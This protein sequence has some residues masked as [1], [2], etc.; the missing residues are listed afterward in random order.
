M[1]EIIDLSTSDV[2]CRSSKTTQ[3]FDLSTTEGNLPETFSELLGSVKLN[4][5]INGL[6]L[7]NRTTEP[8]YIKRSGKFVEILQNETAALRHLDALTFLQSAPNLQV[9]LTSSDQSPSS[10]PSEE[11]DE[12]IPLATGHATRFVVAVL[13]ILA[14]LLPAYFFYSSDNNISERAIFPPIDLNLE[15]TDG[16]R[17]TLD[18]DKQIREQLKLDQME[19]VTLNKVAGLPSGAKLNKAPFQLDWTPLEELSP[20]Q[21]TIRIDLAVAVPG[22][23]ITE[24][25]LNLHCEVIETPNPP[26]V[27]EL[28][29]IQLFIADTKTIRLHLLGADPDSPPKPVIFEVDETKLPKGS[30]FNQETST[31]EWL[32]QP[33]QFGT[34]YEIVFKAFKRGV[35]DLSTEAILLID[36]K[37]E[38]KE[39]VS[40]DD[41]VLQAIKLLYMRKT[42]PVGIWIPAATV[43]QLSGDIVL[44]TASTGKV[45]ANS[46]EGGNWQFAV[47]R[48]D[49]SPESYKPLISLLMHEYYLGGEKQRSPLTSMMNLALLKIPSDEISD[50]KQVELITPE[51]I[52]GSLIES[53]ITRVSFDSSQ[54]LEDTSKRIMPVFNVR[55]IEEILTKNADNEQAPSL[56]TVLV[57]E[58][59]LKTSTG[60]LLFYKQTLLGI[61]DEDNDDQAG[62]F[63]VPLLV[64]H[65]F[66][67]TKRHLWQ[68]LM[69]FE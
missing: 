14:G 66:D 34:D 9:H 2:I 59:A 52:K 67:K 61:G 65:Y 5:S 6:S 49:E 38:D 24:L 25:I 32:P 44:T 42:D 22:G 26:L 56:A 30:E 19:V 60:S 40:L 39:E 10:K 31:F 55:T 68:E 48:Y 50:V 36:L 62:R 1:F 21:I 35:P 43:L 16:T 18:L 7:T 58:A 63:S 45:I 11:F 23:E 13:L 41:H 46:S 54:Y 33:E 64:H 47:G 15:V 29:P 3:T 4:S 27:R 37:D 17:F 57:S 8:I 53:K 12:P 20:A 69:V 51:A 28:T